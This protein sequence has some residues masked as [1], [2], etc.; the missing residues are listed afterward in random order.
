MKGLKAETFA[1]FTKEKLGFNLGP[2]QR[3][4]NKLSIYVFLI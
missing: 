1:A 2:D 3:R 4:A